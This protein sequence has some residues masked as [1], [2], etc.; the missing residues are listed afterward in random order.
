MASIEEHIVCTLNSISIF[1]LSVD[2]SCEG[3]RLENMVEHVIS[4]DP[5]PDI[6]LVLLKL[7]LALIGLVPVTCAM[8]V[9]FI[10]AFSFLFPKRLQRH[11]FISLCKRLT[12][13]ERVRP[14]KNPIEL[15]VILKDGNDL[16]A[17]TQLGALDTHSFKLSKAAW[18]K[19]EVKQTAFVSKLN[20]EKNVPTLKEESFVLNQLLNTAIDS[21]SSR[22]S[23]VVVLITDYTFETESTNAPLLTPTQVNY[24]G[25]SII[26]D[27]DTLDALIF[28]PLRNATT[29]EN[30]VRKSGKFYIIQPANLDTDGMAAVG[31]D[32]VSAL[33]K[34]LV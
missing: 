23:S 15:H 20:E 8:G 22:G 27:L 16:S 9:I 3:T 33:K 6:S 5:L 31:I 4:T 17:F 19:S 26:P 12:E 13:E 2:I 11:P 34:E 25:G 29:S 10:S 14:R 1:S 18:S 24:I 32:L 28:V 21:K 30:T 7:S